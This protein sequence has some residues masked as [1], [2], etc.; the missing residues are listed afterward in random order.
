MTR[1]PAAQWTPPHVSTCHRSM[2][3]KVA[4]LLRCFAGLILAHVQCIYAAVFRCHAACI[5]TPLT[6]DVRRSPQGQHLS[7]LAVD[8]AFAALGKMT[9]QC[10]TVVGSHICHGLK[11][12]KTTL[13]EI[14]T[15]P[16]AHSACYLADPAPHRLTPNELRMTNAWCCSIRRSPPRSRRDRR[17][18][19]PQT[20]HRPRQ[21]RVPACLPVQSNGPAS[22]CCSK[23]L[24]H[25]PIAISTCQI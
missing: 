17:S 9:S 4:R 22:A 6:V 10:L 20:R 16:S 21:R 24:L 11:E 19:R 14:Q 25:A 2:R 23:G 3:A 18:R 5:H 1:R 12:G 15:D 8:F 7:A 13:A